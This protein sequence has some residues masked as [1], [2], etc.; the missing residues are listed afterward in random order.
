MKT[1]ALIMAAMGV[2]FLVGCG[3]SGGG[4]P[5][6]RPEVP[7]PDVPQPAAE[8]PTDPVEAIRANAQ[9]VVTTMKVNSGVDLRFD[10]ESV[11]WLDGYIERNR[12]TLDADTKEKLVDVLGAYLGEAMIRSYGGQWEK[13]QNTWCVSFGEKNKAFPFGKVAKQIR[14]GEG[15]SIYSFFTAVPVVMKLQE[16]KTGGEGP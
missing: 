12:A 9:L 16:K 2:V 5:T 8:G 6:Q 1:L 3:S 15:D 4:P 14:N 11:K 13:Y 10:A 7:R